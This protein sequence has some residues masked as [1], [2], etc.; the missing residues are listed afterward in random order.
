MPGI[1]PLYEVRLL[2]YPVE[3]FARTA[4]SNAIWLTGEWLAQKPRPGEPF[5]PD[6][7]Y[8]FD[9]RCDQEALRTI[10]GL[11][12]DLSYQIFV[13]SFMWRTT[14]GGKHLFQQLAAHHRA[15]LREGLQNAWIRRLNMH[16]LQAGPRIAPITIARDL[17]PRLMRI[18]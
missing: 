11:P 9:V 7:R 18:R 15:M 6:L 1:P 12:E 8:L 3:E 2:A 17:L 13:G 14:D 5:V 16:P 10:D 4:V